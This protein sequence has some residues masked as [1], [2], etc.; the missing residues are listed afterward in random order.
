MDMQTLVP[1]PR[2]I[3]EIFQALQATAQQAREQFVQAFNSLSPNLD[4]KLTLTL[5]P[6]A[7][8]WSRPR[9]HYLSKPL[10]MSQMYTVKDKQAMAARFRKG[11]SQK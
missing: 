9:Y 7:P 3:H 6:Q 11:Q 5:P 4:E 10:P 1:M 8:W 2:S